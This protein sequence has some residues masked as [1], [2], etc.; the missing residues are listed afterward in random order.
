MPERPASA[1]ARATEPGHTLPCHLDAR[2][3]LPEE[4]HGTAD[5]AIA[6]E[7]VRPIAHH[8]R[9]HT[10]DREEIEDA[11]GLF[12]GVRAHEHVSGTADLERRMRPHGLDHEH[13]VLT[14][15]GGKRAEEVLVE[16]VVCMHGAPALIVSS[17]KTI[18]H[19]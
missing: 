4:H 7:Q 13:V 15:N 11:D 19:A 2:H 14:H 9:R 3:V 12:R 17:P 6:D 5:A 18:P 8:R 10:A 16:A 1:A